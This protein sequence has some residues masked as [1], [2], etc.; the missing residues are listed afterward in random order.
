MHVFDAALCDNVTEP[1]VN[2]FAGK[3]VKLSKIDTASIKFGVHLRIYML[4]GSTAILLLSKRAF[5]LSY[6]VV[7]VA[8]QTAWRL[9]Q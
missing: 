2:C 9:Q 3:A 7:K 4:H 6:R 8:R 1:P 5:Y